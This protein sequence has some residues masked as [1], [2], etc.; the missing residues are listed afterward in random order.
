ML[1]NFIYI[2]AEPKHRKSFN[3]KKYWNISVSNLQTK[4]V[5]WNK[6]PISVILFCLKQWNSEITG[7]GLVV[8]L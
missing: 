8:L 4:R 5:G 6:Y 3:A 7:L 1:S 2:V